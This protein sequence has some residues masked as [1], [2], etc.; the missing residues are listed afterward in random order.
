VDEL[1]KG[2]D[3]QLLPVMSLGNI[4]ALQFQSV[5]DLLTSFD[6]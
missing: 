4:G 2:S 6:L 3:A 5:V 1:D